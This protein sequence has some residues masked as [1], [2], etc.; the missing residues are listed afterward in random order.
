MSDGD[1]D[2]PGVAKTFGAASITDGAST[3]L[4]FTL[5]N[6]GTNPAQSGISVGDTLPAGLTNTSATPAVAYSAGCS[7]PATAAYNSGTRVLSGLSGVAMAN[8][9][10]SCTITVAG[11][12][13]ATGQTGTCPNAAQT[14]LAASVTTTGATNASTDQ[15]LSV[16]KTNPGVAKTFGAAGITDG[17]ST[18]LIFTLTN[19]GTNPAQ[20][21]LAVSDTLPAGL[22]F[23]SA[24]PAVSYSSGCSGPAT[25]S[26]AFATKILSGL[27]GLAMSNGTVN[28]TVTIAG[29]TNTAGEIGACPNAAQTNFLSSVTATGATV[30]GTDQCLTVIRIPPTLTKGWSTGIFG[31]GANANLVF[32]LTN[33]GTNPAQS[34]IA[35]TESLPSSLQ[36]TSATPAVNFGAGCSGS[37]TITQGAPDII[38]IT[39]MAMA[40]GTVACTIT[41]A[42]VTNRAGQ[43]NASCAANPAAF[44]NGAANITGVSNVT[45][46]VA[47]Q[48]VVVNAGAPVL[49]KS[50]TPASFVDGSTTTLRFT[51]TNY[52]TNPAQSGINFTDTLPAGVRVAAGGVL[53]TSTCANAV[54]VTSAVNGSGSIAVTGATMLSG[55]LSCAIDIQVRNTA[56]Q[57]NA[58]CAGSPVAFTN[59]AANI[60]ATSNVANGVTASCVVVTTASPTITK[61]FAPASISIGTTSTIS[62]TL[63]NPNSIPLTG[64]GFSDTL[65]NMAVNAAGAAGGSCPGV[66][67]NVLNTGQTS[68]LFA[69]LT[70]PASGSCTVTVV[71]VSNTP[72]VH[73]NT[74]SG[75]SSAEAVTGVV[76]NTANLTVLAAA[77]TVAKTFSVSPI[78]SG[79]VSTLLV[80]ITNPN[81]GPISVVNVTD[82]F[83]ISPG[84]GMV[85]SGAGNTSTNCAG[86]VVTSTPGSVT[87]TA[88]IVPGGGSCT[89]Q[90][91]VTSPTT[92]SYVNTI[93]AG[94][95]TTNAGNNVVSASAT[96]GVNPVANVSV[97]KAG[98]ANVLWGTN[99]TYTVV[100]ANAGPDAADLTNFS[101]VVPADVT[102]VTASCG[103]PIGGAT[104]GVVNVAGNTVTSAITTLPAGSSVTFTIQGTAPQTGTL[105]NSATAIVPAGITDPDDPGR[106]GAG[107][108]TSIV[109]T[110]TVLAPDLRLTKTSTSTFAVGGTA[111]F[112]LTPNNTSGNAP[113]TGMITIVDTLPA[114]L[115]YVAAGSGGTGWACVNVAQTV[116]CTS[117]TIMA[118]GAVGNPITINVNVASNAVPG[119][120]NTA[121]VSGGNEPGV[122]TGN[123]S[124]TLNVPV[125]GMAVN[126]FLT[127]GAQTGLPG[128]SVL[129]THVF[130]AGVAGSVNFTS[131]N[132]PTPVVAGWGVQIY[133]DTNCNGVLDAADGATEL[134]G[135]VA[136]IPGDQVCIIVKSNIPAAVP[137]NAQDVI[138]VSANFVPAVGSSATYTRQDVTTVGATGGAGL[139]LNKS[140]R[141]VTQGGTVG[142]SNTARPGDVLEYIIAYSNSSST[143]LSSIIIS[144]NTPA[145]TNFSVASCGA[146]LPAAITTCAVSVQPLAGGAGNIQ[147]TLG[148]SLNASLNGSVT[149]RVTVQ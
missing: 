59:A 1:Q 73:P 85:R 135:S 4:N 36:F 14:N 99:F 103:S 114:G 38:A 74:A 117:S 142:T 24:T 126:T 16:T 56:G 96:L 91:D 136:V 90:I 106:I 63:T 129:Y 92:G 52:G 20:S 83:P 125:S 100:V 118:V 130:N 146:P 109:V 57:V 127:D 149:F 13:N 9:T 27:T 43:V 124:A 67:S 33:S 119:V 77:P 2:Q 42:A 45:N 148:G 147:W 128:T 10:A 35:F 61:A 48:C 104:C 143:A 101:D 39:G 60:G 82:T 122:N 145:F 7:G 97:T 121:I 132:A 115:A 93:A 137:Y 22:R 11:I 65:T 84:A 17:A 72:G 41:V 46:G 88:G 80:T 53:G 110:T 29:L 139:V 105:A 87:L 58:S 134:T 71:V 131:S 15:C 32:T 18:S 98:P 113:T 75:I 54:T 66:G 44:T 112:T 28:C 31:D 78:N 50:F 8:G 37:S 70:I 94:A 102:A 95:L 25:A 138:T 86:G 108:N 3:S 89:F 23:T 76:S 21:G 141:N 79:G 19:T 133:R 40:N 64:A 26:Y 116:T 49:T 55:Q 123:N 5:T 69:G 34:A 140:V 107:N 81:A 111:S 47:N 6:T 12:S 51:L 120:T 144:D 68:L 62:F 30:A